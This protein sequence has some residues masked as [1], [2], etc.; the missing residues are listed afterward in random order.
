MDAKVRWNEIDKTMNEI[1]VRLAALRQENSVKVIAARKSHGNVRQALVDA[2]LSELEILKEVNAPR[3][4]RRSL[5][6]NTPWLML[7][8]PEHSS[9]EDFYGQHLV[10]ED[11]LEKEKQRTELKRQEIGTRIFHLERALEAP[12]Y[13]DQVEIQF[14]LFELEDKMAML[15][16]AYKAI[17][18]TKP[19]NPDSWLNWLKSW[20]P[21]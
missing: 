16:E 7:R 15:E 13:S 6:Q 2:N 11:E 19:Y 4:E 10:M 18:L 20:F 9:A 5:Y 8:L 12:D 3:K 17:S 14:K 1:A 21:F